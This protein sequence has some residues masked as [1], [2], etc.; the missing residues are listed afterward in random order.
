MVP[1]VLWYRGAPDSLGV[2]QLRVLDSV[3]SVKVHS[4]AFPMEG[5]YR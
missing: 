3:M 5:C 4:R 2:D 1:C